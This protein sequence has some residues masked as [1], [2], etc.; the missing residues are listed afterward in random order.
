MAFNQTLID[1]FHSVALDT[2]IWTLVTGSVTAGGSTVTLAA[3]TTFPTIK[4]IKRYDIGS[5][6]LS[7]QVSQTGTGNA[8]SQWF[9]EAVD[10]SGN[11]V[12][13]EADPTSATWA[14]DVDG[15]ATVS[16]TVKSITTFWSTW[17]AGD[18]VGLGMSGTTMTLYKSTDRQTWTVMG[19]CTV[20]G[21]FNKNAVSLQ[22]SGGA[23]TGSSTWACVADN[24]SVFTLALSRAVS[25]A[26]R[27]RPIPVRL[28]RHRA[29]VST[30]VPAQ[31]IIIPNY[32]PAP[33][34]PRGRG[35]RIFRPRTAAPVPPQ[36]VVPP[37]PIRARTRG[38]KLFR[39]R[40]SAPVPAQVV[41]PPAFPPQP[42]RTRLRGFRLFRSHAA[43]PP[44]DQP[45][46]P[47]QS[48]R[49]RSRLLRVFRAFTAQPTPPQV[50]PP[51]VYPPQ[52]AR[53]RVRGL[54]LFR[55]HVSAPVLGQDVP[56]QQRPR[57]R[58]P[59]L[60]RGH[61]A[62]V[63]P[64]QTVVP[65]V[66][67]PQPVRTRLRGLRIFRGRVATPTPGQTV[68]IAPSYVLQSV[69]SKVRGL[70]IFRARAATV[71]PPQVAATPLAYPPA[72]VRPRTRG[73]RLFRGRAVGPVPPQIA[74][75]PA[76]VPQAVR[77]RV[78]WLRWFRPRATATPVDQA[79]APAAPHVRS[80]PMAPRRGHV[81]QPPMPQPIAPPAYPPH[82]AGPRAKGV[83]QLRPRKS[84]G[85]VPP[86]IVVI[87]PPYPPSLTRVKKRLARIARG[88]ARFTSWPFVPPPP[89][90]P[91]AEIV[92]R[93]GGRNVA[94][95]SAN[96]NQAARGGNQNLTSESSSRNREV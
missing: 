23:L 64:P 32:P 33:V 19:T 60:L 90:A 94:A 43:A 35:L 93:S 80:H 41:V 38:L 39:P 1:D 96:Q 85:P 2:T 25:G 51:P 11:G 24:A 68:L 79:A 50:I 21:T 75:A 16:G 57:S 82:P 49:P 37:S 53:G 86:Q 30:P 5:S 29:R 52:P 40:V 70:R 71:V 17:T 58:W 34:R 78:K 6:I 61:V 27:R 36:V 67:P 72:N 63:V 47:G 28:P 45:S 92:T 89:S 31:Q 87:P 8:N 91:T 59:R 10:A 76:F 95:R 81:A 83:R 48:R 13:I 20:A 69:R 3:A 44:V 66:Y 46:V 4:S 14:F 55:P 18:Y 15:A 54:R 56:G 42:V 73:L 26:A 88:A 74:V 9:L 62:L 7:F 65:P 12:G 77:P 22:I 84:A